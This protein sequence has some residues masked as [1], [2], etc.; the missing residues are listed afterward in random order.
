MR[1]FYLLLSFSIVVSAQPDWSPL[2]CLLAA[3]LGY[4]LFW[5]GMLLINSFKS[6]FFVATLWFATIQ[7]VQ[8][9]WFGADRYVGGYI[10]LFLLLLFVAL[11]IQFGLISLFVHSDSSLYR[12]LGVSGGWAICEWVRLYILSGYS[13]NPVGI[14]L[15]GTLY[16]MQM[17]SAFGIFG[18]SFWI[19][20]TNLIAL[21]LLNAFSRSP[22]AVW[23]AAATAPYLFGWAHVAFHNQQMGKN[24]DYLS[25][26]LVQTSIYPEYKLP[27]NGSEPLQPDLQWERI[28]S[29]LF[30]YSD[31]RPDLIVLSEGVVPYGASFPIYP[32]ETVERAFNTFF[33]NREALPSLAE[34]YVGNAYWAQA[35]ANTFSADVVIGLE[36]VERD[37][38]GVRRAY[39]AAFL[40]R[41]FSDKLE[42]YEKR[43]L[44]PMGEYI[45]FGWCRPFLAKYGIE[46]SFVPGREAKVFNTGRV[47]IGLSICYEET[48]GHLMRQ[49]RLEGAEVLVNLTNDVWYPRSR[50]PMV[51]FLHGRLRAVESGVPLLRS[52]N[53]GITCGIDSLGRVVGMLPYE[54]SGASCPAETLALSLPLYG[55][56]TFYT[57]FG[58]LPVVAFSGFCFI[59]LCGVT[60]YKR[61]SFSIN[62]LEVSPLR[63]N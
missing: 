15:S 21:R 48:Y 46:D 22:M 25:A 9:S 49:S 40:V 52:C 42:R 54:Y 51:H 56:P 10:Y 38:L 18:M 55:Y 47:P 17:A 44:V 41:P 5:R 8:V 23:L 39:N 33:E 16:G 12:M 28:L 30:S 43:V 50:L 2:S 37:E 34:S 6:R 61:K 62:D 53:T 14:A 19:F 36:D 29:L 13:W 31:T 4:A 26:L 20:L 59:L 45:P 7:S 3:S 32:V 58:D 35:L 24:P 27:F 11:G 60:L 63:K 1:I 57:Q